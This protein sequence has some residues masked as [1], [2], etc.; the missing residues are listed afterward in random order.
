MND[1]KICF[2]AAVDD[3][4]KAEECCKYINHL[5]IPD[6]YEIDFIT[7]TEAESMA[8]A[9]QNGMENTDA[10]YK[11]Y[12]HQDAFIINPDF[13]QDV[14][15]VF[16]A[17]SNI[18]M[19]GL[20]GI[21]YLPEN[22]DFDN[23]WNA[24]SVIEYRGYR[25]DIVSEDMFYQWKEQLKDYVPEISKKEYSSIESNGSDSISVFVKKV[26]A[27][28]GFCMVTSVDIPWTQESVFGWNYADIAHAIDMQKA[29]YSVVIPY[30]KTPW[31]YHDKA[32][33]KWSGDMN[34]VQQMKLVYPDI[35]KIKTDTE[36]LDT[37]YTRKAQEEQQALD[38]RRQ[39]ISAFDQGEYEII[40]NLTVEFI[41]GKIA[42]RIIWEMLAILEFNWMSGKKEHS[43]M[44][45][46]G[47]QWTTVYSVFCG[48]RYAILRKQ[49]GI[50]DD[51]TEK[52]ETACECGEA[53]PDCIRIIEQISFPD[54]GNVMR[55][56]NDQ[57]KPLVSV[58][59]PVYNGEKTVEETLRSITTQSYT[60]LE[61]IIVDDVS[62]DHSRDIIDKF[63][64]HDSRIRKV[65]LTENRNVCNAG[66]IA[67]SRASGKYIVMIGQ[68]DLWRKEKTDI[69]IDFMEKHE[70]VAVCFSFADVIDENRQIVNERNKSLGDMFQRP[71]LP[72]ESYRRLL[73]LGGN[74]YC[75]PSA[76]IRM[77]D[78]EKCGYYRYGLVQLQDYDLWMRLMMRGL[79]YVLPQKLTLYRRFRDNSNLS[80]SD[81]YTDN[82]TRHEGQWIRYH[83]LETM[84]ANDFKKIMAGILQNPDANTEKEIR[85]EKAF[86]LWSL[87]N[88]FAEKMFI[89]LLED[90]E[91]REIME[92][93]YHFGLNDFYKMNKEPINFDLFYK[94]IKQ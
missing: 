81:L 76:C 63:A 43:S 57:E 3:M 5:I 74:F 4:Q 26:C 28:Q 82:R 36:D 31:C 89:E 47:K 59:L 87:N 51:E 55:K 15:A 42:D 1:R 70:D 71:N 48:I 25:T 32:G 30:Q 39:I 37:E 46:R 35:F 18:G 83:I 17:D 12:L 13:I 72:E 60:N 77:E 84:S 75:A 7:I 61:I 67:F 86:L 6:G 33:R 85:I 90:D 92:K 91:I 88:C 34:P 24:G 9:Y 10:K 41:N 23:K 2:I 58:V 49:Y 64:L 44:M 16:N 73:I 27:V 62:T 14:M 52:L 68:D 94:S 19:I 22:A 53:D 50:S 66:N 29:G 8:G 45:V 56:S 54:N 38:I 80:A 20:L 69:Q 79:L 65:Y 78:L 11:V 40:R 93:K 21:D